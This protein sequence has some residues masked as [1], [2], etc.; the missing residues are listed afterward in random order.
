MDVV[1]QAIKCSEC[2]NF[3]VK[4]VMLPC[5]WS[6]CQKH[7][8]N[9]QNPKFFCKLCNKEH[10]IEKSYMNVNKALD[11]LVKANLENL[12]LGPEYVAFNR[13]NQLDQTINEIEMIR[14]NASCFID[15][16]VDKLKLKTEII[17]TE[18]KTQIDEKAKQII[19][20]LDNYKKE[21]KI[22]LNSSDFKAKMNQLS[23]ELISKLKSDLSDWNKTFNNLDVNE[24]ELKTIQKTSSESNLKLKNETSH[25]K[26]EILVNKLNNYYS[27]VH[28]FQQINLTSAIG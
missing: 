13:C 24:N 14:D 12:N 11:S 25:I 5:G 16:I 18:F 9:S 26:K 8:E 7:L 4:P 1:K 17:Q 22:N 3:L 20:L 6:V 23:D 28:N 2:W 21:C 27:Y 15:K 10:Q 19:Q